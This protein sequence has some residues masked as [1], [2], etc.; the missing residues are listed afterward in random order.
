[1]HCFINKDILVR[2]FLSLDLELLPL[3]KYCVAHFFSCVIYLWVDKNKKNIYQ[4]IRPQRKQE[5]YVS[6]EKP[7]LFISNIP[8]TFQLSICVCCALLFC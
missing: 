4:H 2:F 3:S 7:D 8:A 1:M 5:V 6:L